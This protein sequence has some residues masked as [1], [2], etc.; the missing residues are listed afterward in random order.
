MKAHHFPFCNQNQ[1]M[2]LP[3]LWKLW[4]LASKI[5]TCLLRDWFFG[6]ETQV[7]WIRI[8]ETV[9]RYTAVSRWKCSA[10]A[11]T[12][13]FTHIS[14]TIY[15]KTPHVGYLHGN[16]VKTWFSLEGTL[17]YTHYSL[18]YLNSS[19]EVLSAKNV[20][21]ISKLKAPIMQQKGPWVIYYYILYYCIIISG[22]WRCKQHSNVVTGQKKRDNLNYISWLC[23]TLYIYIKKMYENVCTILIFK[24][25]SS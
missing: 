9:I 4:N 16:K 18:R 7:V 15:V 8:S 11:L 6:Y 22:A 1:N 5:Y 17:L 21:K 12:A 19:M 13:Y 3:C 23:N 20:F 25:T 14:C 10:V 24:V 2:F